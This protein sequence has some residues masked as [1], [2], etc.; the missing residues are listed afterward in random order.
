MDEK[1]IQMFY[2][3]V[4]K[5]R[6]EI[7]VEIVGQDEIVKQLLIAIVC[8]GNVLFEG[9]PGLGK[10]RLVRT[11]GNVL[12]LGFSRIQ[13]TPDLM[14]ADVT[15]TNIIMKSETGARFNACGRY[16]YKYYYEIRNGRKFI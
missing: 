10:T 7:A 8:G 16:G 9:V 2:T 4:N 14:P 3:I 12:D 11:L 13:F 15:G 1:N 5:I 6:E